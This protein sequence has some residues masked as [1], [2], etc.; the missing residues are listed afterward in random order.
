MSPEISAD[1]VCG[2]RRAHPNVR[3][4][5]LAGSSRVR[6][7]VSH[8]FWLDHGWLPSS[9]A[10][11][12]DAPP[13]AN[14]ETWRFRFDLWP[15]TKRILGCATLSCARWRQP[16]SPGRRKILI[17]AL[18]TPRF[19]F[20]CC[21]SLRDAILN[22]STRTRTL[23]NAGITT[24]SEVRLLLVGRHGIEPWTYG[25]RVRCSTS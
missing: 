21:S 13:T 17:A 16:S 19:S 7:R 5:Q 12:S 22:L 15:I 1:V 9:S 4:V 20:V 8:R 2:G 10:R 25:L 3:D 6:A 11:A 18:A 14:G 24:I 23:E